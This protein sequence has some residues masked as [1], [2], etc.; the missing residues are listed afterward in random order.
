MTCAVLRTGGLV[1]GWWR[2]A[3]WPAPV[4]IDTDPVRVTG[5]LEPDQVDDVVAAYTTAVSD[6]LP[7]GFTLHASGMLTGPADWAGT[8]GGELLEQAVAE[9]DLWDILRAQLGD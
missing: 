6:R 1:G 8:P 3:G 4:V 2:R 5:D 9:V 7:D